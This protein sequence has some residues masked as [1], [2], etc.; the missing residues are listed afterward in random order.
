MIILGSFPESL[1]EALR[2]GANTLTLTARMWEFLGNNGDQFSSS[3]GFLNAGRQTDQ[4]IILATNPATISSGSVVA[5][6]LTHL[7]SNGLR[8]DRTGTRVLRMK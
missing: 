2:R 4:E 8:L 6:E 7:I 5:Q 1:E 3:R